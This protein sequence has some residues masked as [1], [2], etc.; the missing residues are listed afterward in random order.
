MNVLLIVVDSLRADHLGCYGY[1]K[2]TSPN[3]DALARE[4]T[5]FRQTFAPGIPTTPAFTTLLSGL[6]PY[7]HGVLSHGGD[8]LLEPGVLLLPQLAKS[9]GA[10]TIAVDNLA[11]QGNGRGS[12]F[13]RGF[14]YYSA[15]AY[16]PFDRQ[17]EELADRARRF[18]SE[19][20]SEKFFLFLHLWDPHTPYAPPTPF[21]TL[22]YQPESTPG[23][24]LQQIKN[25][26]P[27]Y[28]ESFLGDMKFQKP[29]DF[30]WIMAQYD[31]EISYADQ[32]IGRIF[33]HIKTLNLWDETAII[34]MS[35]HGEC[36]GEGDFWFDHHGL[37]DANLRVASIWRVPGM[38]AR[39]CDDFV[40]TEDVLPTLCELCHWPLPKYEIGGKSFVPAL[41][42]G[43]TPARREVFV[44]VECSRQ[45]SLCVRT[46]KWK[47]IVPIA[48]NARG[49]SVPNFYGNARD[50]NILL[51][52]LQND[53]AE[54]QDVSR[55]YSQVRS[56]LLA[57]L[58]QWRDTQKQ[59][60]DG[61]DLI[62][63][64][65]LG[66]PFDDFMGRLGARKMESS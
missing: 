18:L 21:D 41:C 10:I 30:A 46:E 61:H 57:Q 25:L 32:Q 50:E 5:L 1:A 28:Y 31:G 29:D 27:E 39:N 3:L 58:N 23:E 33:E 12:W 52:D 45:A 22:H 14:D 66:L 6:H 54:T 16:R 20:K 60:N 35:D 8:M 2:N 62:L 34:V 51:F 13:T 38:K 63:E 24:K 48:K 56:E 64:T 53:P 26:A 47:L 40:S 17:S 44:G 43:S 7:R 4:G 9:A 19:F 42:G 37:Y 65:P 11:V 49:H 15:F 55:E 59:K 36:F